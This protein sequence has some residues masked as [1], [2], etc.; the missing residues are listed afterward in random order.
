MMETVPTVDISD[1][2]LASLIKVLGSGGML[3]AVPTEV[4]APAE[5]PV[6]SDQDADSLTALE[7]AELQFGLGARAET[8]LGLP[9][10]HPEL[11]EAQLEG[12]FSPFTD[13]F[14]SEYIRLLE[15]IKA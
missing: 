7:F 12:I 10:Y 6:L 1:E 5:P 14:I 15:E 4:E 3:E 11:K 13:H 9:S 2:R 8:E